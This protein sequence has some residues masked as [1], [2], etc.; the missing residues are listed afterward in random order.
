[1]HTASKRFWQ[2]LDALPAEIQTVATEISR[3]LRPIQVIRHCISRL[4]QMVDFIASE[5]ASTTAHLA[6][7]CQA[8]CIGFGSARMAN[9]TS[10][11]ANWLLVADA[12][13]QN[14]ASRRLL[15]AGQLER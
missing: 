8:A 6:S 11:S 12:Q 3:S 9:M 15:R 4:L 5:S 7:P 10:L 2:C 14:A 1:M 13:H